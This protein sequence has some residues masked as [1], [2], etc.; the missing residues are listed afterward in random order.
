MA[1]ALARGLGRDEA[2]SCASSSRRRGSPDDAR[3]VARAD[4]HCNGVGSGGMDEA[5]VERFDRELASLLAAKYPERCP[6]RIRV[7][8]V[9]AKKS[10]EKAPDV[11]DSGAAPVTSAA[12][13]REAR[14]ATIG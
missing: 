10:A 12:I 11:L 8:C 2:M 1:L 6:C 5:T 4:A 13:P 3:G 7:H 14:T 9:V